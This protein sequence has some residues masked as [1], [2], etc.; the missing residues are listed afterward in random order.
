MH[1]RITLDYE[2]TKY[3]HNH[4]NY[5]SSKFIISTPKYGEIVCVKFLSTVNAEII[6]FLNYKQFLKDL[7]YII[8]YYND[9]HVEVMSRMI[10]YIVCLC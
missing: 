5:L 8:F 3:K 6:T 9:L 4:Y 2:L 10:L 7:C 1:N